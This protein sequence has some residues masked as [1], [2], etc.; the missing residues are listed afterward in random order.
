MER[1]LVLLLVGVACIGDL[2]KLANSTSYVPSVVSSRMSATSF[3]AL[4]IFIA[5][6]ISLEVLYDKMNQLQPLL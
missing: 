3:Y 6:Y 1:P 5:I 4:Y 2:S